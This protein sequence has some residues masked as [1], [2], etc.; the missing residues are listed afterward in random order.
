[1]KPAMDNDTIFAIVSGANP[2]LH[3]SRKSGESARGKV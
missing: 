2:V 3:L 1:M